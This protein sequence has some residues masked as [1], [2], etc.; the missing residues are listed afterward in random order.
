MDRFASHRAIANL[1]Q[2]AQLCRMLAAQL[3]LEAEAK[4][5]LRQAMQ[6]EAVIAAG[7]GQ[8]PPR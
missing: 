3:S 2:E 6:L 1:A 8:A 5:L 7:A 4:A